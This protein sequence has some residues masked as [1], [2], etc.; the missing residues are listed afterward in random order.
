MILTF[1]CLHSQY[2]SL[3]YSLKYH[4]LLTYSLTHTCSHSTHYRSQGAYVRPTISGHDT[5]VSPYISVGQY[6]LTTHDIFYEHPS[7]SNITHIPF[8]TT[9]TSFYWVIVTGATVG[10]G[11]LVP[12]SKIGRALASLTCIMG[13]LGIKN[14]IHVGSVVLCSL[15]CPIST[16]RFSS[17][18]FFSSDF[19]F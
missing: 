4:R 19:C 5:E 16:T 3:I 7:F 11:D 15:S 8:L 18:I 9:G 12:T 13:I 10:Y 2:L 14:T 6:T 17:T 1:E